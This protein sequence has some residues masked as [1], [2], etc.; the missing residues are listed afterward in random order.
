[1]AC[2]GPVPTAWVGC[3]ASLRRTGARPRPSFLL[4]TPLPGYPACVAQRSDPV[5]RD[6]FSPDDEPPEP[7]ASRLL[8]DLI[9][10]EVKLFL[11]GLKDLVL[12]PGAVLAAVLGILLRRRRN[13]PL[14]SLM[15]LGTRFEK[16][17]RLYEPLDSTDD[18]AEGKVYGDANR[19]LRDAERR[20][21]SKRRR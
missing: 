19:L 9:V 17:L 1:M 11:D 7:T 15:R 16:W 21:R 2:S 5:L 8:R 13:M 10:F 20:V 3:S 4:D 12:A 6:D 14:H 18:A